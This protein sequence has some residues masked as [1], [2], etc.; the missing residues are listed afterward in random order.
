MTISNNASN[1]CA[2]SK[3]FAI[4][5]FWAALTGLMSV[6]PKPLYNKR[7]SVTLA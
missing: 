5:L 6:W 1:C 7:R 2:D 3:R 4:C